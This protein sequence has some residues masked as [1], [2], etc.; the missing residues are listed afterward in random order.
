MIVRELN[1]SK[2]YDDVSKGTKLLTKLL[3][4]SSDRTDCNGQTAYWL[5][6]NRD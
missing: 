6:V 3:A 1:E 5:Q 2:P 4:F